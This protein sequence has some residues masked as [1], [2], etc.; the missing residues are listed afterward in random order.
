[1]SAEIR[2]QAFTQVVCL[3][4]QKGREVGVITFYDEADKVLQ[5][6]GL[7]VK[8]ACRPN[9]LRQVFSVQGM[10]PSDRKEPFV[11]EVRDGLFNI[12][13]AGVLREDRA[14]DH[15]ERSIGWPPFLG[16]KMIKHEI[17]HFHELPTDP[18]EIAPSNL[19]IRSFTHHTISK[20]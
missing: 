15:F 3:L 1:M 17:E 2:D 7:D 10:E 11:F 20:L 19:Y 14:N 8:I 13:P 18:A 5:S 9:F 6:L 16:S 4:G 12:P